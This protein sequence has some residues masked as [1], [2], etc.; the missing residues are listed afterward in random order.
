MSL[1]GEGVFVLISGTFSRSSF[2]D[3]TAESWKAAYRWFLTE[4]QTVT[5]LLAVRNYL[6]RSSGKDWVKRRPQKRF[7]NLSVLELPHLGLFVFSTNRENVSFHLS[8]KLLCFHLDHFVQVMDHC[9]Y[10]EED[11]QYMEESAGGQLED[12][13]VVTDANRVAERC[14]Q[15]Y[16]STCVNKTQWAKKTSPQKKVDGRD[17]ATHDFQIQLT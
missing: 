9:Q 7:W 16:R 15:S 5:P 3:A 1:G 12:W 6:L 8:Y 4:G 11:C 17:R 14:K 10:M 2:P 13:V